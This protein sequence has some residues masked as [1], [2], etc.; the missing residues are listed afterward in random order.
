MFLLYQPCEGSVCLKHKNR[1]FFDR[2]ADFIDQI[3][4]FD[5]TLVS[6]D[7]NKIFEKAK[8]RNYLIHFSETARLQ[9]CLILLGHILC[10]LVEENYFNKKSA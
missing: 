2:T 7:E 3:S 1:L 4:W 10:E 5:K 8:S 9:E 6:S